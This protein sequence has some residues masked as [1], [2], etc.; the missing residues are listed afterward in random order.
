MRFLKIC[1]RN[2]KKIPIL[3]KVHKSKNKFRNIFAKIKKEKERNKK[4]GENMTREEKL[5]DIFKNIDEDK[6]E[7]INP[8]IDD[9]VF[10][11]NK[12]IELR[13]LPMIRV[14]PNNPARQE[15]TPAGKMYKEF[16]QSY[17]NALK[18]LQ[19]ALYQSGETGDS[20]LVK[21]LKE[22]ENDA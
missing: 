7:V 6:R 1:Y 17:L 13:K 22:F 8:L 16:M 21:A 14:H 12:L 15:T 19:R 2:F 3:Q 5:R 11:E 10:I 4:D 20:P 18:V 9:V